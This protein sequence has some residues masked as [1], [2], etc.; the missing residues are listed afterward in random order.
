MDILSVVQLGPPCLTGGVLMGPF[1]DNL[2][3]LSEDSFV[4]LH[5]MGGK[6]ISLEELQISEI[7]SPRQGPIRNCP[8]KVSCKL[9]VKP[10]Y[11]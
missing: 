6:K 11:E 10:F 7:V 4:L 3:S 8:R 2:W 5:G 9:T 1:P